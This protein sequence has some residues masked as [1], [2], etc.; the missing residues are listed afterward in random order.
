MTLE[1]ADIQGLLFYSYTHLPYAAYL[2]LRFSS[3]EGARAWLKD[4][5]DAGVI[6]NA[7]HRTSDRLPCP[8]VNVAF[9]AS[10]LRKIGLS[11]NGLATFSREFLGGMDHPDR[12]RVL[13]D[14]DDSAP[15]NWHF[16][17]R[18]QPVDAML[19][20]FEQTGPG[21]QELVER[22]RRAQ[23]A[24]GIRLVTRRPLLATRL[25]SREHFGFRDGIS[26][27]AVEGGPA[28]PRSLQPALPPGEFVLD[29]EDQYRERRMPPS[30]DPSED[31]DNRLVDRE[32]RRLVGRNGTYLVFRQL[33]QDVGGFWRYV[34]DQ[35]ERVLGDRSP[36][37][38][39]WIAAKMVGRWRNGDSLVPGNDRTTP[40]EEPTNDFGY[41]GDAGGL[42]CPFGA[43]VRRANP[44]DAL[45]PDGASS[46][47]TVASHRLMRRG[48]SYGRVVADPATTPA[49]A[50]PRG[51]FFICLNA[52]LRSQFE[53]VQQSWIN[54]PD[55]DGLDDEGDPLNTQRPPA[56]GFTSGNDY[57]VPASPYRHRL[58]S[59]PTFVRVKGGGYFFLPGLQ[60]LRYLAHTGPAAAH[61]DEPPVEDRA[62]VLRDLWRS[63]LAEGK[64]IADRFENLHELASEHFQQWVAEPEHIGPL[65]GFLRKHHPIFV[66]PKLAIVTRH[67]DVKEVLE[68]RSGAFRV[69]E[70]Y[71]ERMRR[72]SGA[73]ML[74]MENTSQYQ[75]EAMATRAALGPDI[76]TR[77]RAVVAAECNRR[78]DAAESK[79][80][81]DLVG[82]Y[83][84]PVA[85]R[86]VE[87]IFGV[88]GPDLVTL[89]RWM[90][91]IF[92]EI[93]LNGSNLKGVRESAEAASR[94]MSEYL[95]GL[96]AEKRLQPPKDYLGRLI[97]GQNG[98]AT[99]LDDDAIKR[100]IGGIIVGAVDT[101]SKAASQA[102]AWLLDHP[103]HLEGARR[104]AASEDVAL[105]ERYV[106][107]AL[108][109]AP[110]TPVVQRFCGADTTIAAGTDRATTIPQGTTV[111]VATLAA[112]FDPDA[113]KNP[114]EFRT[115]RDD[116]D[117]FHFGFAQHECFG[118]RINHVQIPE[119]AR[120]FFMRAPVRRAAGH[121][122]EMVYEGPF[123]DRL[124]LDFT[125]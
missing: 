56:N 1:L 54:G 74:G 120:R 41:A 32:G 2:P 4:L 46:L 49:D 82:G 23:A 59:L 77:V 60:A 28:G 69:T 57:T 52:S 72:T 14:V 37:K 26:Q 9:S 39:E 48:R 96:I 109:F 102:I 125:R 99:I 62:D 16:G 116:I 89:E 34:E 105:L 44:R 98:S 45:P 19:C 38:K 113:V 101:T 100:N 94:E 30:V 118:K 112:S 123:P 40:P 92:W 83:T 22:H 71:D 43:H 87:E 63:V 31:P 76:A 12:A 29:Y 67:A 103:E 80:E 13:G 18:A 61:V 81:L 7:E 119:L 20:L 110:Q 91:A 93:F 114:E 58:A 73:F 42:G 75:K 124:I 24:R 51:L 6:T 27:P 106:F 121:E 65:L 36:A 111:L 53:F 108:R 17:N 115:D 84:R 3:P 70:I 68:N 25:G 21:L 10:G 15:E 66:A 5:I 88:P 55:F 78:L 122:G 95:D 33:A 35:A 86:V 8:A 64:E 117:L 85:A 97:A 50:E 107:E 47:V 11:E 79:G 90:R 104:A